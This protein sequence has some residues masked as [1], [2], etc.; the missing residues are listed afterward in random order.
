MQLLTTLV[1]CR[2]HGMLESWNH[3]I[4][5]KLMIGCQGQWRAGPMSRIIFQPDGTRMYPIFHHSNCERSELTYVLKFLKMHF[6]VVFGR[7]RVDQKAQ[8][9]KFTISSI[10]FNSY[11]KHD[12]T[13]LS[14]FFNTGKGVIG[15]SVC[16]GVQFPKWITIK[17][18]RPRRTLC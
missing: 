14:D 10:I 4:M 1:L 18:I 15:G 17:Q 13:F 16:S 7:R 11:A 5:P 8:P 12:V 6:M 2:L 3:G 9:Q